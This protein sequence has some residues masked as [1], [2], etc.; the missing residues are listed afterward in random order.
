MKF[1]KLILGMAVLL[2][3]AACQKEQMPE[4]DLQQST[5]GLTEQTDLLKANPHPAG[6]NHQGV[7]IFRAQLTG[8]QEVP[9]VETQARGQAVFQLSRDGQQLSFRVIVS[10]L[11]N[12]T[13]GHIHLAPAGVNGP[14]VVWLYPSGPPPVLIPG[15]T[16]GVLATG[17]ITADDLVGP[18]AGATMADLVEYLES[19]GAYVNLH[20][21]QFPA[22]EIRGQIK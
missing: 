14:V 13:M 3:F 10:Q 8:D 19:E 17:V 1:K 18:L 16:N 22:G 9:P 5:T 4:A 7:R 20:T 6:N 21:E 12:V 11:H 2:I 15:P